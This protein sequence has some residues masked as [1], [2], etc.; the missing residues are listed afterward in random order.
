MLSSHFVGCEGENLQSS[1]NFRDVTN[2]VHWYRELLFHNTGRLK[3][4]DLRGM[5]STSGVQLSEMTAYFLMATRNGV[6]S[7]VNGRDDKILLFLPL[8]AGGVP[9]HRCVLTSVINQQMYWC[10][11]QCLAGICYLHV[12]TNL[13]WFMASSCTWMKP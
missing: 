8:E 2:R 12:G 4:V 1:Q 3:S 7:L 10:D 13:M 9:P 6:S 11:K 5:S